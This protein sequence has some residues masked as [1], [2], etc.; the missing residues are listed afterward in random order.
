MNHRIA[1]MA[2]CLLSLA[3]LGVQAQAPGMQ[4]RTDSGFYVGAGLGRS[5]ARDFCNIGGSCDAKD[6]AG[7]VFAGYQINRHFA[8]EAGYSHFG[9]ATSSGFVGGVAA[10][11]TTETTAL[12]LVGV[13]SVPLGDNFSLYAKLGMFRYDS[14]GTATGGVTSTSGDDGF[15]LTVGL[16]AEYHFT[17]NLTGRLEWQRYYEVGSGVLNI[18]K[19]D[20]SVL[21]L[22]ARYRF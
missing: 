16:G 5:E 15:E 10:T 13:G 9:D 22:A 8:I 4:L 18:P 12:E 6:I 1:L 21:R 7:N 11:I 14:D 19:A 17:R 3:S 2:G 20:I